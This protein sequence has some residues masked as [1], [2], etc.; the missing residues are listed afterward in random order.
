[1]H[2]DLTSGHLGKLLRIII[3]PPKIIVLIALNKI[4]WI[5]EK[6]IV[7]KYQNIQIIK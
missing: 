7:L 5:I 6:A 4:H 2:E 3:T 1:M